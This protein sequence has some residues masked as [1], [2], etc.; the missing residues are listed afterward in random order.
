MK[1]QTRLPTIG[2]YFSERAE[3]NGQMTN[4]LQLLVEKDKDPDRH[5]LT[6]GNWDE[7]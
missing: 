6:S 5:A 1:K 2:R 4:M 3:Q 7:G